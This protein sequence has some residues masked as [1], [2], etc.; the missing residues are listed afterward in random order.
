MRY[1]LKIQN[2]HVKEEK[3]ILAALYTFC[4]NGC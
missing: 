3:A 2:F 1:S 4:S